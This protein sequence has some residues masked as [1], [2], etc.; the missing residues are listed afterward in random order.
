M[1]GS[2]TKLKGKPLLRAINLVAGIAIL[3]YVFCSSCSCF[4]R[5]FYSVISSSFFCTFDP[6]L[7]VLLII[8]HIDSQD[9]LYRRQMLLFMFVGGFSGKRILLF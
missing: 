8:K 5:S 7:L 1:V 4:V 3:L 2:L 6:S 9:M